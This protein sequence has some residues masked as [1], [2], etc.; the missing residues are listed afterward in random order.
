MRR[1]CSLEQLGVGYG[2]G[3]RR[4]LRKRLSSLTLLTKLCGERRIKS[5]CRR[6]GERSPID[7]G[8]MP[9]CTFEAMVVLQVVPSCFLGVGPRL[10][11]HT[12]WDS[13]AC[14]DTRVN[15]VTNRK[16]C[17]INVTNITLDGQEVFEHVLYIGFISNRKRGLLKVTLGTK[18]QQRGRRPRMW[19]PRSTASSKAAVAAKA[20]GPVRLGAAI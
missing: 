2:V 18:Q 15:P 7:N 19:M 9:A 13:G 6:F 10:R 11:C 3:L 12:D 4:H 5:A 16:S 17:W 14:I 8:W 1:F 20:I